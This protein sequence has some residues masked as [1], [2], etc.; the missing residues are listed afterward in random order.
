VFYLLLSLTF[1]AK[2]DVAEEHIKWAAKLMMA[3]NIC[4]HEF[5]WAPAE[6]AKARSM[7]LATGTGSLEDVD[8]RIKA[9]VKSVEN[10]SATYG[11]FCLD[12]YMAHTGRQ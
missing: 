10:H 2:P 4:N 5:G 11:V 1:C 3:S 7:A 6:A 9:E 8:A 12:V